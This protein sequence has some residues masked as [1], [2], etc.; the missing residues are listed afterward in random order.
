MRKIAIMLIM[1][2]LILN[3][4]ACYDAAEIDSLLHILTIGVDKG[5]SDKWRLTLQ[6]PTIKESGGTGDAESAEGGEQ[7]GYIHATVDAPSFYTGINMLNASLPRK[8]TFMNAQFLVFSEEVARAG[9][10]DEFVTPINRFREMRQSAN[11]FVVK[12][13]AD[14]FL[15]QNQPLIGGMISND[16]QMLV[17]A[18]DNTGFFPKVTFEDLY[19]GLKSPNH[20]PFVALAAINDFKHFQEEGEPWG[21]EFKTGGNYTAGQLPRTGENKIELFGTALFDGSMMVGELNG[22]ETRYMLMVR[23]EFRRGFFSIK[24]PKKP[25]MSISLG[26]RGPIKPEIKVTFDDTKPIIHVKMHLDMDILAIES[27]FNYEQSELKTLLEKEFEQTVKD[28]VENVIQKCQNLNTDVFMF[29]DHATKHFKTIDD[30]ENYDWNTRF[31]DAKII[32]NLLLSVRQ[33]WEL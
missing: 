26:V 15:K 6:F 4:T 8:L 14:E 31:R 18:S 10:I 3:L 32:I 25:E 24:D 21:T 27:R 28:G 7:F 12:G 19:L 23:D 17:D 11:V 13:R 30:L 5:I 29:G 2:I 16:F 22:D 9:A 1:I 33:F 20:Q